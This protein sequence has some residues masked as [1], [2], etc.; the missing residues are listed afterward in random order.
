MGLT[1]L[2]REQC[3]AFDHLLGNS[4]VNMFPIVS[5][6]GVHS[7]TIDLVTTEASMFL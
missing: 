7:Y 4:S 6:I 2:R 5:R 1:A 3:D